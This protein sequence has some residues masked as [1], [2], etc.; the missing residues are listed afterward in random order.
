MTAALFPAEIAILL[1]AE[2]II[3]VFPTWWFGLPTYFDGLD[4]TGS[5]APGV[6]YEHGANSGP[7]A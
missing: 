5:W 7:I 1:R 2:A 4:P 3:L 6:T